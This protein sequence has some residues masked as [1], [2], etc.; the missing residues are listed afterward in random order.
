MK[1]GAK[2]LSKKEIE[3]KKEIRSI[4]FFSYLDR[5]SRE[6]KVIQNASSMLTGHNKSF[7]KDFTI[8]SNP[9]TTF[10]HG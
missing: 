3:H 1:I 6:N 7:E 10:D 9:R 5:K 4:K 2:I 8:S